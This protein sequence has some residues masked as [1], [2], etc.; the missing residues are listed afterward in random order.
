MDTDK[1]NKQT[2]F[3]GIPKIAT[4]LFVIGVMS[5][6]VHHLALKSLG[7]DKA[8]GDESWLIRLELKLV[9]NEP[10]AVLNIQPP[11]E[12]E[13]IRLV[14]RVLKHSGLRVMPPARNAIDKRGIRLL[15]DKTGSYPVT[16]DFTLQHSQTAHFH[17]ASLKPLTTQRREFYLSDND[18]LQLSD[19]LLETTLLDYAQDGLS[20]K[21]LVDRIFEL[22]MSL[23]S[24]DP[25]VLRSAPEI[26]SSR[27]ANQ[28]ERSILMTAL[29]RRAGIPARM[30]TGLELKA[31]TAAMV[32]YW[33]EVRLATGWVPYHP[34]LGYKESLPTRLV[35]LDKY[36]SGIASV[37]ESSPNPDQQ[38]NQTVDTSIYVERTPDIAISPDNAHHEWYQVFLLDRLPV[39]TRQEL[40]LLMLLP[41]G[42]L[43]TGLVKQFG[44]IHSYGVFTP[45]ILA[46]AMIYAQWEVTLLMLVI[47]LLL[48][49]LG[50]PTFHGSMSRTPRL[51]II[52]T[53]V[54]ISMVF[55]VSLLDYMEVTTQSLLILLP[56][57]I[58]TSL[59][60]RFFSVT[61][62]LGYH[63]AFVRL[64]WTLIITFAILPILQLV[65]LGNWL[66]RY[67]EF[68][69]ITL[70][71]FIVISAYP[72]KGH[73][74]PPWLILLAEP[75]KNTNK[76]SG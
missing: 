9:T 41:L 10:D 28:Q 62:S 21:E 49:Y 11:F 59:I 5:L 43:L 22:A 52:F 36:G 53:L 68:H 18:W 17:S 63:T 50:R 35:A 20:T 76:K 75:E 60:D 34:G 27:S 24:N 16:I 56:I 15:A 65:W 54:A 31:D 55:G 40:A 4:I 33:V 25:S 23:D 57:V 73:K 6:A 42:V 2:R 13:N 51:S 67:P 74:L 3:S 39:D 7:V 26:L 64:T 38:L 1:I 72:V 58:L 69:L 61:E 45:T 47:I 66:L 12:S 37:I 14:G 46:L 48:V 70:A 19:L 8:H 44:G 71:G 32:G 29:C 30:V